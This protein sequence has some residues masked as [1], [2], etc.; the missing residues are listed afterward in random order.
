MDNNDHFYDTYVIDSLMNEPACV[1]AAREQG[2][3]ANLVVHTP[4]FVPTDIAR[5]FTAS[6]DG[7]GSLSFTLEPGDTAETI[8]VEQGTLHLCAGYT[9]LFG[10]DAPFALDFPQLGGTAVEGGSVTTTN[11][12]WSGSP[13]F[14]VQWLRCDANGDNCLPIAGANGP[15]YTPTAADVGHRLASRITATQGKSMS[16][17]SE[18]SAVVAAAPVPGPG[19]GS[20]PPAVGGDRTGPKALLALKRTTLQKVVK[21]GFIP[22]TV[23][24]DEACTIALRA[25]VARKLRKPLGGAKI[26]SGKGRAQAGKRATIKVKL[27][28]KARKGLRRARAVAFTLT[29]TATDAAGNTSSAKKKARVR[30]KR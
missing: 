24:C 27:T 1:W 11:G 15:A 5:D 10:S 3:L 18:P 30:R 20:G 28:L 23:T 7:T 25:D 26:A 8:I 17:D 4:E 16:A 13:A 29:A 19:A 22:V 2:C 6:D 21:S 14:A 12:D 9:L